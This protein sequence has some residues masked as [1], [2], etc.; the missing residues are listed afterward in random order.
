MRG[1][2]VSRHKLITAF[3]IIGNKIKERLKLICTPKVRHFWRCI[4]KLLI[5]V[6]WIVKKQD[7]IVMH[8]FSKMHRP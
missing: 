8:G 4:S 5:L 7:M 3:D 2:T 1:A 6:A